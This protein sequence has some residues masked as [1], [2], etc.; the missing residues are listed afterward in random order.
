M[1]KKRKKAKAKKSRRSRTVKRAAPARK[2]KGM[3]K[4]ARR[5]RAKRKTTPSRAEVPPPGPTEPAGS[6]TSQTLFGGLFGG[7]KTE[8]H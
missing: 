3:K 1:A 4:T 2:K 5:T 7:G 8:G 6:P